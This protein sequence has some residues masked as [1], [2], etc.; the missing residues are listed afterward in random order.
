MTFEPW[1]DNSILVR[2]EHL[3][4][5]GEDQLYSKPVRFNLQDIFRS[6]SI[7]EVRETTLAGN[8]WKEDNKRFKFKPDPAYLQHV[9]RAALFGGKGGP[10]AAAA[11]GGVPM[12]SN[13]ETPQQEEEATESLRNVSN[14]GYE[15]VLGPMQIRTFVLQLEFR[16]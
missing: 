7:D 3:L 5:K 6:L 4:E 11:K 1:K 14:E 15:I 16:P 9:T 10:N 13:V 8:Q 2:F 12:E